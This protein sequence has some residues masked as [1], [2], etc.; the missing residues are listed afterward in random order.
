MPR[1]SYT[2]QD[3]AVEDNTTQTHIIEDLLNDYVRAIVS[4]PAETIIDVTE[5]PSTLIL[6]IDVVDEDRGKIIGRDGSI[7]N[8][9]KTIFH[10]LGCKHGKKVMLEIRE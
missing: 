1:A 3:P 5:S 6:T 8:S 4:R 7:I 9:L 10:A 2:M